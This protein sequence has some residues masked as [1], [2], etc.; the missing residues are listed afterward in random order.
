[1]KEVDLE[2]VQELEDHFI[3][4]FTSIADSDNVSDLC[5]ELGFM[6]WV[7][8]NAVKRYCDYD[9]YNL[10]CGFAD[11]HT[12]T[13]YE[14]E[15]DEYP[16]P[17]EE[18]FIVLPGYDYEYKYDS[19]SSAFSTLEELY[20][21]LVDYTPTNQAFVEKVLERLD[22][23]QSIIDSLETYMDYDGIVT[24]ARWVIY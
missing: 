23:T 5:I 18:A 3:Q 10:R 14:L 19:Y 8:H 4:V 12:H 21:D 11:A 13:E 17:G 7:A 2:S 16:H 1:M 9:P 15:D 22:L 24:Q 20:D 6:V